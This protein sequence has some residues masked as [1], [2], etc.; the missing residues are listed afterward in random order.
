MSVVQRIGKYEILEELGQGGM[1]SVY[2]ARDTMIGRE[3]ALKVIHEHALRIP[4]IKERFYREAKSA[5]RLS[6]ENIMVL[7]DIFETDGIPYL[8]MELLDG[9]DLRTLLSRGDG[10]SLQDKHAIARQICDGLHHAHKQ[11]IIHR[12][13]KPDNIRVLSSG[14]VKIMDFGIAR[15]QS[16]T[17]LTQHNTSLGTPRYMSPEQIMGKEIDHRADIFSFGVLFYEL[18]TGLTPFSG[19]HVTTVIYKILSEQPEPIRLEE[20]H[21]SDGLQTIVSRCLEKDRDARYQHFGQVIKDLDVLF[22]ALNGAATTLTH[23]RPVASARGDDT[24]VLSTPVLPDVPR[25]PVPRVETGG[26]RRKRSLAA[27]ALLA[28]VV[29]GTGGYAALNAIQR[30]DDAATAT[31]KTPDGRLEE[32]LANTDIAGV[33][34]EVQVDST[35]LAGIDRAETPGSDP[36]ET[37]EAAPATDRSA[38]PD[39]RSR[40]VQPQDRSEPA[41][42]LPGSAEKRTTQSNRPENTARAQTTTATT[43]QDTPSPDATA[44]KTTPDPEAAAVAARRAE[45]QAAADAARAAMVG[46]KNGVHA[47]N[48]RQATY[49]QA[50]TLEQKGQQAYA[51]GDFE[52]AA[53]QFEQAATRFKEVAA[54]PSPEERA[55]AA[56]TVLLGQYRRALEGEDLQG[57]RAL[58]KNFSSVDEKTWS[59]FFKGAQEI[60]VS[61]RPGTLRVDG[62]E[63]TVA[64]TLHLQYLDNKKRSQETTLTYTW[65][66]EQEDGT[67]IIARVGG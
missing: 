55:R 18:L 1:G 67:W 63:A 42:P 30:S 32:P 23:I 22:P 20:P 5:G 61:V 43:P 4:E 29:L 3:V 36:A 60:A 25:Q 52:R 33:W 50:L 64:L 65:E 38:Q 17:R 66:L 26:V 6:H 59:E 48:E 16:D 47:G 54:M 51:A 62:D 34:P 49:Q 10:L 53:T 15:I 12:D 46:E 8:V 14:R 28:L 57:L 44:A 19:D 35:G 9:T 27:L 39:A 31:P 7:H 13:I 21:C 40:P 37:Q 45:R 56:V 58:F 2:K 41:G 24:V 11:D